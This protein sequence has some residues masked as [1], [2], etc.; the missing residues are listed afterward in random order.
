MSGSGSSTEGSVRWGSKRNAWTQTEGS[1][2]LSELGREYQASAST[3]Y[4]GWCLLGLPPWQ[5]GCRRTNRAEK[6]SD[7]CGDR[8]VRLFRSKDWVFVN[9]YWHMSFQKQ[10]A[11]GRIQKGQLIVSELLY[12]YPETLM[13]LMLNKCMNVFFLSLPLLPPFLQIFYNKPRKNKTKQ[14]NKQNTLP[15]RARWCMLE[16]PTLWEA[17]ARGLHV[18][19]Q[20]GQLSEPLSQDKNGQGM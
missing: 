2:Q 11:R 19:A 17:G 4:T 13:I 14:T 1:P 8:K 6:A 16:I 7:P 12:N 15:H 9:H 10:R 3:S 20:P 5:A 18:G